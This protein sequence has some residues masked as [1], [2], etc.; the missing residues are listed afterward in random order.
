[1]PYSKDAADILMSILFIS[2]FICIFYFTYALRVEHEILDS[3]I[4]YIVKDALDNLSLLPKEYTEK[5]KMKVRTITPPNM[6]AADN[7]VK[8]HN[9]KILKQVIVIILTGLIIGFLI[10]YFLAKKYKFGLYDMAK[11]NLVILVFIGLTEFAFLEI[12]ARKYKSADP[13]FV[14]Y[15]VIDK[16]YND[17]KFA[18]GTI[19]GQ[20][21]DKTIVQKLLSFGSDSQN[22]NKAKAFASYYGVD[23]GNVTDRLK[24]SGVNTDNLLDKLQQ[25]NTSDLLDK[26]PHNLLEDEYLAFVADNKEKIIKISN[27]VKNNTDYLKSKTIISVNQKTN[28]DDLYNSRNDLSGLNN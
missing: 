15:T 16:L 12:F 20:I 6:D 4:D 23:V 10:I 26:I 13:N 14:K 24:S 5:L 27:N 9:S 18:S 21:Q 1:M 2:A 17:V 3:Q 22:I 28:Y 8:E 25:S 11:K 19:A 7:A